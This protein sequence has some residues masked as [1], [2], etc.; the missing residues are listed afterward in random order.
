MAQS[1]GYDEARQAIQ[2]GRA[3][4]HALWVLLSKESDRDGYAL[5]PIPWEGPGEYQHVK[6]DG[7]DCGRFVRLPEGARSLIRLA[8]EAA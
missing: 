4:P 5:K 7:E 6:F 3:V 1:L 8:K 2:D